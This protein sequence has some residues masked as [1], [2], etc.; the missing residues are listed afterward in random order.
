MG[1]VVSSSSVSVSWINSGPLDLQDRFL[2]ASHGFQD[3]SPLGVSTGNLDMASAT[4]CS[5]PGTWI[6]VNLQRR[7]FCLRF[8]ILGFSMSPSSL[9]PRIF[10][11]GLWS[12]AT[13]SISLP[14]VKCRVFWRAHATARASP[15]TGAYLDSAPVVNLLPARTVF[16]PLEQH[17]GAFASHLQYCWARWNPMPVLLQ[18]VPRE[19]VLFSSN[20]LTPFLMASS[21]S[22]LL[23]LNAA[24]CSSP[25]RSPHC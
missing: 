18:S 21:I 8:K 19:V 14:R 12:T 23:A 2:L 15:S 16:Q 4:R 5:F 7:V 24:L 22:F 25:N 6:T 3:S 17:P 9:S 1:V 10:S 20:D 11:R 13:T